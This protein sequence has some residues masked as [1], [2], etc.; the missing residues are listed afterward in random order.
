MKRYAITLLLC[1]LLCGCNAAKQA[2]TITPPTP[3]P[4][5]TY[6][7]VLTT[8]NISPVNS[9]IQ[10][11]QTQKYTATALDQKG[12]A[13]SGVTVNWSD[14]SSA[15]STISSSGVATGPYPTVDSGLPSNVVGPNQIQASVGTVKSQVATLNVTPDPVPDLAS[16]VVTPN[17]I[18]QTGACNGET[19][20]G[21][22][23]VTANAYTSTGE[24]IDPSTVWFIWSTTNF[25]GEPTES[26]SYQ[27]SGN[28]LLMCFF[29]I[30]TQTLTVSAGYPPLTVSVPVTVTVQQ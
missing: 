5:P 10:V 4:T 3:A 19:G 27:G 8:L 25:S 30:G 26:G 29:D 18:V 17:P 16:I 7:P 11:G 24:L 28:A 13:M 21:A 1:V 15:D 12:N 14:T 23:Q 2:G 22:T 9:T 20:V 6:I